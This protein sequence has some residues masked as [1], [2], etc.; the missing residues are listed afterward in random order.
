MIT[1]NVLYPNTDSQQ[2][3][4]D[5]YLGTHMPTISKLLGSALK[6]AVVQHGVSGGAPGSKPEFIVITQL[7]FDSV[8]SFQGAFLPH[9]PWVMGD[10]AN[11]STVPPTIQISDV[12]LG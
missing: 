12:R 4:M 7:K 1:V 9:A 3:N 5:Y 10:L 2:F 11:F 6:G 8:E